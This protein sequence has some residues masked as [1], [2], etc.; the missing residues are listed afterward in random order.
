MTQTHEQKPANHDETCIFCKI[1]SGDI[2]AVKIYEN[3]A[4][5]AFLDIRPVHK[6]HVLVIP[7]DHFENV[8]T[9]PPELW[10]RVQLAVQNL[11]VAVKNAV[12]A[13]GIN[14]F[15]NNESAAGQIV[16]HAHIHIIPRENEDNLPHWPHTKYDDEEEAKETAEKIRSNL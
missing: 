12:S 8:Y 6:G 16:F 4:V 3:D 13:D 2:P 11:A 9:V 10:C 1:V 15:M 7:K 14:V 5:L